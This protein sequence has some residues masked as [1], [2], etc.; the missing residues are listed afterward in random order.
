MVVLILILI[1]LVSNCQKKEVNLESLLKEI[2]E[3]ETL[4]YFPENEYKL[5]QSSSYNRASVSPYEN[6]WFE[7]NDMSHFIR[8]EENSGRREFVMLD[9][10]GPG[11][12]VR[13]WMT[14]YKAQNGKIRVYIDN[15]TLATISGSPDSLLSETLLAGYPFTA[16]LLSLIHIS[17]PTRPY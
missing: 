10:E 16:S 8:I 11:A 15:D 7:N 4:T 12:I 2:S 5:I 1:F 3:R 14:F 17:E 13:W 9:S 6:G